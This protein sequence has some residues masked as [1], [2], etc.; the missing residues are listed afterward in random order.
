[1]AGN[2][3]KG[4]GALRM[5]FPGGFEGDKVN[6][7]TGE[8]LPPLMRET[9]DFTRRLLRWRKGNEVI[10]RGTLRHFAIN[11]G[12]YVYARQLGGRTVTVILNGNDRPECLQLGRYAE[13]LPA[14]EATDVLT[15][16]RI[17]LS[18]DCLQLGVRETLVLEF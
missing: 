10:A 5:N 3:S 7:L 11:Q 14:A 15:G 4:D 8:N 2:K 12:V 18:Q 9:H 13:V 17:D 16:R 6:A 1:M